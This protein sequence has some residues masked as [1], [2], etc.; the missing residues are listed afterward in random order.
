MTHRKTPAGRRGAGHIDSNTLKTGRNERGRR[1][2]N[3]KVSE[4]ETVEKDE[5]KG[6]K[7]GKHHA[8]RQKLK[9]SKDK[10]SN[11]EYYI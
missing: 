9:P 2:K 4:G 1:Q 8:N 5:R 6:G 11:N 7:A 3:G 10:F